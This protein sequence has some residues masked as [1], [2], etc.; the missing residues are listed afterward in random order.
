MSSAYDDLV[1][2]ATADPDVVGLILTGSAARGLAT[3]YSDRDVLVV[4]DAFTDAWSEPATHTP[5][6]DTIPYLVEWI[7]DTRVWWTRWQYRGARIL[8]D[9]TDGQV[10]AGL[11]E[12]QYTLTPGEAD[13]R[14]REFLGA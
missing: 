11:C 12:R 8:F 10:L 4:L 6:L 7:A 2:R 5:E 1:A 9:R 14:V 13:T 3:E